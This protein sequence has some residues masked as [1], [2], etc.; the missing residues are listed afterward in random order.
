MASETEIINDVY[1]A[2]SHTLKTSGGTGSSS[3][4]VQGAAANNAAAVGNPVRSGAVYNS[5]APIFDNGDIA[6][7]QADVNGN[8]KIREQYAPVAEDNTNGV[9]ATVRKFVIASTYAGS[10]S[11]SFGTATKANVVAA[12]GTPI[13]AI[14]S[15]EN[16]AVRYFQLHNKTTD[17]AGTDVPIYSFPIP[18]GTTNNPGVL[19][20]DRTF[21]ENDFF[22]LG[23]GWAIST[24]KATF[25]DSATASEHTVNVRVA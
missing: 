4:T 1:D 13:S 8:L 22:T 21:F 18:A 20:L 24:T 23:V 3:S 15:N 11:T 5:S 19:V 2:S 16:A 7:N 6:D 9:V 17:P 25:T 12:P 10:R 14:V